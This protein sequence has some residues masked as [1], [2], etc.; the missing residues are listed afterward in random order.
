MHS[1]P[2]TQ[3]RLIGEI[4]EEINRGLRFEEIFDR[5]HAQLSAL[6]PCS[7]LAIGFLEP[8]G[9]TLVLGPVRSDGPL[10]LK[11]R[12]AE[13]IEGSSLLALVETGE[14]RIIDD[15]QAYLAAKPSSRSTRLIVKEGMRSS[16]TVPLVVGDRRVG[17]MW[18]SSRQP[19]AY[20]IEHEVFMRTIAG[21]LAI[22]VE[23]GWLLSRLEADNAALAEANELKARFVERLE[24]EVALQTA[25]LRDAYREIE[26]LRD[27]LQEENLHLRETLGRAPALGDFVGESAAWRRAL[28]Q[29]EI[30]A[31][32]DT[33][34]LIRG[35]TGTGKEVIARA[36]HRLSPRRERPFVAVNC[37]ALSPE[38]VASELFGHEKG[39]FTGA[40]QRKPGRLELADGG[41]LFLDEVGDLP[42]DVQVKLLRVLQE[43]EFE[44]VGGTQTIKA[45]LRVVAATNRDLD[46]A[47][48]AGRFRDDLY[49]RL[50]VFPVSTPPLRERR[51]D[52]ELLVA[53]FAAR[54]A[55]K[56]G[57]RYERIDAGSLARCLRYDWPGNVR[58]LENAVERSVL[59]SPGP[60][61]A[62]DVPETRRGVQPAPQATL[63]DVVTA[64]LRDVLRQT[65]GRIYG[66]GGAAELLGLKPSTLQAKLKK[67]GMSRTDS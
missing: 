5:L 54:H 31:P 14:T 17:V 28:H 66:R 26:Q 53:H 44:R 33:T 49:Y 56:V 29:A 50:N 30:V 35:E 12:Y 39:A 65:K 47:R 21:H 40:V 46:E 22:A 19:R 48:A 2:E 25:S 32:S 37:G 3:L 27:R 55:A 51:E 41:T 6:L 10:S 24:E 7:R 43:R 42:A 38:L 57:R 9:R 15:L 1:I 13:S 52:I 63:D 58:E 20:S 45:N 16:L 61:L 8:D 62:I 64:H 67:Y 11:S 23:K 36:I 34:V 18:F 4:T 60:V 59:L